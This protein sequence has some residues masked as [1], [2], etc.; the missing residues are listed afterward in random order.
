M[1]QLDIVST[2]FYQI[3][4][5]YQ[6]ERRENIWVKPENSNKNMKKMKRRENLKIRRKDLSRNKKKWKDEEKR[7]E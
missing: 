6:K 5:Y 1:V 4:Q 2:Y 3:L 7:K